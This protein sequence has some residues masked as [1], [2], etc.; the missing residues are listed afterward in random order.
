[1]YSATI[2]CPICEE[3]IEV[4]IEPGE[5]ALR[6]PDDS[7]YPGSDPIVLAID[8]CDCPM[9]PDTDIY[10]YHDNILKEVGEIW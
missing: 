10:T 8:G 5:P 7:G 6:F 9:E 1:M 4:D 3:I 2:P